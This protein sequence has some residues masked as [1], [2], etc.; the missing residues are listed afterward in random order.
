MTDNTLAIES[1]ITRAG[2][3]N[4]VLVGGVLFAAT[5]CLIRNRKKDEFELLGV[6]MPVKFFPTLS[7]GYT[8]AHIYCTYL[9]S[10][11]CCTLGMNLDVWNALTYKG[12]FIFNG[13]LPRNAIWS[14]EFNGISIP[15]L[16]SIHTLD[17]TLWL[18]YS[19][20]AIVYFGFLASA[21]VAGYSKRASHLL[22]ATLVFINWLT[23]SV[24]ANSA[25]LLQAT[26]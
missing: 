14:L 10:Q 7:M 9:F 21:S 19:F 16:T 12:P 25:S 13:M 20:I 22:A 5:V 4:T 3:I 23:G 2:Y 6:E 26:S 17:P 18:F 11:L 24:W 8:V 1:A 15:M